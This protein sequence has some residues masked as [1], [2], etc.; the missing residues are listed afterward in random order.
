VP[1][2]VKALDVNGDGVIDASEIAGASAALL[3]LDKNSDGELTRDEYLGAPP[4]GP[5]PARGAK[6]HAH[7]APPEQ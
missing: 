4:K 7:P 1:A 5:R 2:I 3:K 6:S